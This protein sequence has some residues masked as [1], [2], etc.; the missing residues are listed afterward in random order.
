MSVAIRLID[1]TADPD[2]C[3]ALLPMAKCVELQV[4]RDA[5]PAW[6]LGPVAIGVG[7][8]PMTGEWPALVVRSLSD[9]EA[10]AY[11]ADDADGYPT[12]FV[13]LDAV[14]SG[15]GSLLSGPDSLSSAFSHEVLEALVDPFCDWW[16][17][18]SDERMVALEIADP[19]QGGS[20][21]VTVDGMTASVSNFVLPEWF[22]RGSSRER[23]DHLGQLSAP[24]TLAPG[25]YVAFKDGTQIF[26]ERVSV[27]A[28][29]R[30]RRFGR[31]AR[32]RRV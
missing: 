1:R 26:G 18:W 27:P 28:A 3:A 4:A 10:L 16:S 11:H 12:L 30:K 29:A 5:A 22:R 17:E 25:G 13:G 7:N 23:F 8:A 2:V 19:V 32:A 15:G 20:Y 24:L 9:P 21:D 6:N 31:R 14:V